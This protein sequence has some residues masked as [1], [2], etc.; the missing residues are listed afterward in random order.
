M[1]NKLSKTGRKHTSKSKFCDSDKLRIT[2]KT[3]FTVT[4]D[5][6]EKN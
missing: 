6:T 2:I 3:K 1:K 4:L 5:G